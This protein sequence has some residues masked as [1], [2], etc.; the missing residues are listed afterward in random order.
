MVGVKG[1]ADDLF[2]KGGFMAKTEMDKEIFEVK[3]E[4]S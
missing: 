3:F 1:N 2:Y 4:K